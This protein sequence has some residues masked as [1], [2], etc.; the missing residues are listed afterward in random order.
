MSSVE[1]EPSKYATYWTALDVE[2]VN[3]VEVQTLPA[4]KVLVPTPF[5]SHLNVTPV[6]PTYCTEEVTESLTMMPFTDVPRLLRFGHA[7][8]V[9][10]AALKVPVAKADVPAQSI[11][12]GL[13]ARV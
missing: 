11:F 7:A 3:P 9:V 5:V 6:P 13:H 12:V 10:V 8:N 2:M 1:E 4:P